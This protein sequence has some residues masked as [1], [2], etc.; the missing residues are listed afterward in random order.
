MNME[1]VARRYFFFFLHNSDLTSISE[2]AF[3]EYEIFYHWLLSWNIHSCYHHTTVSGSQHYGLCYVCFSILIWIQLP[4]IARCIY[5]CLN[6]ERKK[7]FIFK[8]ICLVFIFKLLIR[9]FCQTIYNL[10]F[11]IKVSHWKSGLTFSKA[12][13]VI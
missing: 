12:M 7:C 3:K 11:S 13:F 5:I 2:K 4:L 8:Q 6:Q 9:Y 1:S 10:L